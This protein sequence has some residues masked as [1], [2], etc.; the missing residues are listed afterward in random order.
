MLINNLYRLDLRPTICITPNGPKSIS[1]IIPSVVEKVLRHFC[2]ESAQGPHLVPFLPSFS[3]FV[4]DRD[5]YIDLSHSQKKKIL[6]EMRQSLAEIFL[7]R[8]IVI[9][10]D[11]QG[12]NTDNHDHAMTP[13]ITLKSYLF[14]ALSQAKTEAEVDHVLLMVVIAVIH[15]ISQIWLRVVSSFPRYYFVLLAT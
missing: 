4:H 8:E 15:E 1:T 9:G 7:H 3:A 11:V 2:Q 10:P 5:T 12:V 13:R 14:Q 6:A